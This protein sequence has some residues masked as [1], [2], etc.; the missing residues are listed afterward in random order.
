MKLGARTHPEG[1]PVSKVRNFAWEESTYNRNLA[2][3]VVF[4]LA[5]LDGIRRILLDDVCE[6]WET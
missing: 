6:F 2:A 1:F 3:K 5:G 4:D